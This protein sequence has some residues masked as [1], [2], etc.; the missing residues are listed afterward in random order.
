MP[1]PEDYLIYMDR[2]L[3][4]DNPHSGWD[5]LPSRPRVNIG[6]DVRSVATII[7][8][9]EFFPLN[10]PKAPFLHPGAMKT[11]Y[12]DLRHYTV[13]DY[14]NRVGVYR[15]LRE[16]D[17][18]GL[19][20][21]FAVNAAVA[22]AY[23]SLIEMVRHAGHE[24]AAHGISTAHIH[25]DGLSIT[26]EA[27]WISR[28]RSAFPDA[29]SWMS[30]ARNHGFSTLDLIAEAGFE[31]CLDWEADQ[32]P[33]VFQT[34]NGPVQT[35][36]HY[37]ELGDFKLLLDRSHTE[38]EWC[39]QIVEAAKYSVELFEREGASAL[40]F[41]LTPYIA[42]QPFRI[43]G[44]RQILSGLKRIEGLVIKSAREAIALFDEA[45]EEP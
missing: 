24:V 22:E 39:E 23:P 18:A 29:V 19:P 38:K 3:G 36:P 43:S 33:V 40:A 26:E 12:P 32:R 15:I 30:P 9:L 41:T 31:I 35:L 42:G 37:N 21:T 27:A 25:H 11:P 5:P 44:L 4:M 13:R 17:A 6:G 2:K 7:V 28:V 1:L 34:K 14:G 20:A 8:P 10:P 16:L 45:R